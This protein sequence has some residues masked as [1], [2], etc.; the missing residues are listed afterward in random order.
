M[1]V[2]MINDATQLKPGFCVVLVLLYRFLKTAS[3][4]RCLINVCNKLKFDKSIFSNENMFSMSWLSPVKNLFFKQS[5]S[6][7][8]SDYHRK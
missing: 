2:T 5:L 6:F 8:S 3:C 7:A 4:H 1:R